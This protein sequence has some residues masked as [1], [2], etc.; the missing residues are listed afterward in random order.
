MK[1]ILWKL[2][3]DFRLAKV[4]LLLMLLA[5]SLS[6]WGIS[7]MVYSY[8][9]SERDFEANFGQTYPADMSVLIENYTEELE[10]RILEDPNVI[11]IERREVLGGRVKNKQGNWMPLVLFVLDDLNN[12]RYDRFVIKDQNNKAANNIL[13]EQKAYYFLDSHQDSLEIQFR[14][15]KE[16]VMWAVT[17]KAHDARLAPA[18]ME[19]VV[20]AYVTSMEMAEP[21]LEPGRRR[22]LIK[23]NVSD[24]RQMLQTVYERLVTITEQSGG[25]MV[26][27]EIPEPGE[28]IHQGIV[29]GI[30]F[31]QKS[32]G[33]ILS[34]MGI[35]LLSLILLTWIFPQVSDIGVMKAIGA[36][37]RRIFLSYALVLGFIVSI[38]LMIGMPLGY[39]TATFYN[40]FVSTFQNF[41][42]VTEMLPFHIHVIVVLI[43]MIIPLLFGILPLSKGANTSVND[44]MNR[45]FYTPHKKFFQLSQL[46]FSSSKLKYGLNNLLRHTQRTMLTILLIAVGVALYFTAAN[47]SYSI[48]KDMNDFARNARY[49]VGITMPSEIE[50]ADVAFLDSLSFIEN[51]VPMNISRVTYTPPNSGY[52]ELSI[53]RILSSE[54]DID[55]RYV[56]R[57]EIDKNCKGCIYVSGEDMRREFEEVTLGE[58]INLSFPSGET[59]TYIFS[60]VI[61]DLVAIGASF[62]I[63]D[64]AATQ[65]FNGLAFELKSGLSP[66]EIFDASNAID[67]AF[68]DNGINL[69]SRISVKERTAAILNHLD[70]TFFIIRITGIFTIVL[71]LIGLLIVLSLTIQERTREIG[72][73]KSVGSP[74]WK[75]SNMFQ[76]EFI[77]ISSIAIVFGGLLSIPIAKALINSL[78]NNVIRHPVAFEN[79][80]SLIIVIAVI[81]AV[82]TI[83]ITIYNRIKMNKN[84]R[85]LLDHSF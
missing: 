20:Y 46:L 15:G 58:R 35:I 21:Y 8:F 49:E 16:D 59:K 82:Q 84:A 10:A 4:K 48:R 42:V 80:F 30:S 38:G 65:L 85:E 83:L 62:F 18:T 7:S 67:D 69:L 56:Q 41:N 27:F 52:P 55:E 57:G 14:G 51:A 72:I 53:A 3:R 26:G 44:A 54:I 19:G 17:G 81:L 73:M 32:G 61:R 71:G 43:G 23:S 64:D 70:P 13:I 45:T 25:Q 12:M 1:V 47:V 39:K 50:R 28:H 29:D 34:V 63:Y 33:G 74:Y 24:D 36:S 2:I 77:L 22:L 79:D 6:G 76:Q 40:N 68:I 66:D 78:A 31:L 11:D 60:G 37:T 9:M 5:A 75:I